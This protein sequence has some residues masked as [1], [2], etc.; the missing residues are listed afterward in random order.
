MKP[1]RLCDYVRCASRWRRPFHA[2]YL[3]MYSSVWD[4]IVTDPALMLVPVDDHLVHRGDG[5]FETLKC[6]RGAL[7]NMWA[8]LERLRRSADSISLRFP[9]SV[10]RLADTIVATVRAG[11][12]PECL[13]RVLVSRGPGGF[14]VDPYESPEPQYYI[15]VTRLREPS[16][17]EK[18]KGVRVGLSRI[19]AKPPF[20]AR[21]KSCNYLANVLMKKEAVDAHLDCV[22]S[23]RPNGCIAEGPTE[24]IGIVTRTRELLFPRLAHVLRGTTMIRVME[25]AR[26]LVR[27]GRL[28]RVRFADFRAVH[29]RRAAEAMLVGTTRDITRIRVFDGYPIGTARPGPIVSE[30]SRLLSDDMHSNPQRRTPVF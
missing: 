1:M 19:P 28:T 20:Y 24:N 26:R 13:I 30:L 2:N 14:G 17:A 7:Y 4:R 8:H 25:L 27:E 11:Q 9:V 12:E 29:V 18:R 21:V 16:P 3:A 15:I 6:T 23:L 10:Q 5:V 22:V